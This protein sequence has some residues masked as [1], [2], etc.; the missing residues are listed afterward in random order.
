MIKFVDIL[1]Y[2]PIDS[3]KRRDD[4]TNMQKGTIFICMF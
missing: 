1:L 3:P 2:S 4:N